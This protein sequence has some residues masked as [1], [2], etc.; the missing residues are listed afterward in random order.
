MSYL[1]KPDNYDGSRLQPLFEVARRL[2]AQGQHSEATELREVAR[3]LMPE[4]TWYGSLK[5]QIGHAAIALASVALFCTVWREAAGEMPYKSH[6]FLGM[7]LAYAIGVEAIL[8]KWMPG[9]SW[10][11]TLCFSFGLAI[12]LVP[13]KE[14][15]VSGDTTIIEYDHRIMAVLIL[16]LVATVS[17]RAYTRY[18]A[19]QR[20][21]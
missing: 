8:Q 6:L 14:M 5:N 3:D 15:Q 20:Q 16:A 9:D 18:V 10:V 21:G 7:V 19:G 11:D 4:L 1:S 17:I 12:G 2:E 13:F